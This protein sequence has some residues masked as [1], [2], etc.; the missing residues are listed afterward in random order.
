MAKVQGPAFSV[1]AQGTIGNILTYQR[2]PGGFAAIRKPIPTDHKTS[3][4][5]VCRDLM[6]T[7]RNLW[8]QLSP[9][10][11]QDWDAQA[12]AIGG[13]SG[14]NLFIKTYIDA[15]NEAGGSHYGQS[16]YGTGYYS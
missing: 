9:E 6:Y 5:L 16:K 8:N 14:Y 2:R 4:Q 12:L 7:A 3:D 10:M 1:G 11:K 15:A 13:L